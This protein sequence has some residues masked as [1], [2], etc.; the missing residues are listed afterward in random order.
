M[1]GTFATIP[2]ATAEDE[3]PMPT[4]DPTAM[5]P[6]ARVI[7]GRECG[8]CSLCCKVYNIPE[9]GKP[10]GKWCQHCTPGKGCGIHQNLPSQCATFNCMWRT[11]AA[12][13]PHWKPEHSKMVVTI[14][15]L[16]GHIYVQVDSS[17]PTAWRKQPYHGQLRL[18]AKNNLPKGI[19]VVVFVN[20]DATLIMPDQDMPLGLMKPTDVISVRRSGASG[21]EVKLV[22]GEIARL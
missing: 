3:I 2:A 21:Y 8:T 9:L 4:A 11:E 10:A 5:N 1:C 13:P 20:D 17:A 19:H 14:F 6:D 16:N 18:W 12:L 15:P 7:P 22:P